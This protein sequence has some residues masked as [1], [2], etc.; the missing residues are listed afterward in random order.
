[1]KYSFEDYNEY[2][3]LK[4]PFLLVLVNIYL[5]KQL[6]IF[7]LP[8]ISSIPFLVKFAHQHFSIAL[9][10]SS[11][12]AA[13]VIVGMLRRVPK[14]RSRIIRWIWRQGRM[15]LLFNLV[16]EV[17]FIILFIGLGIEKFNEVSLT[18]I[19]LDVVLIIFLVKSQQMQDVFAEFP[20]LSF[21]N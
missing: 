15:L 13:L 3:V 14:T 21:K 19:Y 2:S 11:I 20:E 12:P 5:L 6:L 16:L 4:I 9:L 8:M 17:S 10:L 18:F 1:M 7:V